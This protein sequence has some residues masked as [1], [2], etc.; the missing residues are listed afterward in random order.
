MIQRIENRQ[1]GSGGLSIQY[2]IDFHEKPWL[3]ISNVTFVSNTAGLNANITS[4]GFTEVTSDESFTGRGG[5]I[6]LLL[7]NEVPLLGIIDNCRFRRNLAAL[8]G[9]A[10]YVAFDILS[11]HELYITNSNF[12][13][14]SAELA[15][16]AVMTSY[17]VGGDDDHVNSVNMTGCRLDRNF[18]QYGGAVYF[19][20]SITAGRG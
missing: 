2:T 3:Y 12:S 17:L 14:N 20:V 5:A 4:T 9:G 10:I 16:G 13:G 7:N 11:N 1:G 6:F 19:F 8:Y 15:G 18:A